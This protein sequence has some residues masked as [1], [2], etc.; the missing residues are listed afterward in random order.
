[1]SAIIYHLNELVSNTKNVEFSMSG[2]IVLPVGDT[3]ERTTELVGSLRYNSELGHVEARDSNGW[4][5]I[6]NFILDADGDTGITVETTTGSDDDIIKFS[7]QDN[8][9]G[10]IDGT[11][12]TIDGTVNATLFVGEING[13]TY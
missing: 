5:P 10:Y 13:G 1:M 4:M 8:L 3:L 2:N 9:I 12:M 11:G 6:G 7:V